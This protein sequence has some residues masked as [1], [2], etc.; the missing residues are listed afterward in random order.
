V[1]AVGAVSSTGARGP[2]DMRECLLSHVG[3]NYQHQVS[4]AFHT[5]AQL[6][7]KLSV[8]SLLPHMCVYYRFNLS[9]SL[10][11]LIQ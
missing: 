9:V 2:G 8:H 7:T 11:K 1:G 10:E 4:P 5:S 6:E 3:K